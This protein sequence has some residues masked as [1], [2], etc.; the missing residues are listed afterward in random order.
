MAHG[1]T[2]WA[3]YSRWLALVLLAGCARETAQASA[4]SQGRAAIDDASVDG[5][6]AVAFDNPPPNDGGVQEVSPSCALVPE[7]AVSGSGDE[8]RLGIH[9]SRPVYGY[10]CDGLPVGLQ[11][12][13]E[14]EWRPL[15]DERPAWHHGGYYF[16]DTFVE[17]QDMEGCHLPQLVELPVDGIV[18]GRL[19]EHLKVG[20]R[21]PPGSGAA[22]S[23]PAQEVPV[24]ETRAFTGRARVWLRYD[25]P[26]CGLDALATQELEARED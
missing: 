22:S 14:G 4:L 9:A 3:R 19:V 1:G 18:A 20:S 21:V 2:Q 8:V 16:D 11:G 7:L 5:S 15:R 13:V 12:F 24:F 10:V 26:E 23:G 17:A 6:P 25:Y